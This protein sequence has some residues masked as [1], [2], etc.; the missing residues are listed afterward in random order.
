[1]T[2]ATVVGY[3]IL[4]KLNLVEGGK[5]LAQVELMIRAE[6]VLERMKWELRLG[7]LIVARWNDVF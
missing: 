6:T 4:E 3:Q 5:H 1:M 2:R 7:I